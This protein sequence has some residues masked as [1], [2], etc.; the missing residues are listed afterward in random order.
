M[1]Q[2]SPQVGIHRRMKVKVVDGGIYIFDYEL[3]KN[4]YLCRYIEVRQVLTDIITNNVIV[5]L[6]YIHN[7]KYRTAVFNRDI[8]VKQKLL[9]ELP[10]KGLDVSDRNVL[11]VLDYLLYSEQKAPDINVHNRLGWAY[12]NDERVFLHDGVIGG[13]ITSTYAGDLNIAPKGSYAEWRDIVKKQVIGNPALELALVLGLSSPVASIFRKLI[14]LDVLFFHIYGSSTTG[15]TTALTLATS[16]FGYPSKSSNGLIKTWLATNNALLAYLNGIHGIP[17]AIDEA[18]VKVRADYTDAI[19]Q[20]T[21]G[22]EKARLN[23]NAQS[24]PR[25]EW[26]GTVL[27]TAENSLLANSNHNNGLRVRLLEL[28]HIQWTTSA[29]NAEAL[30]SVL[31][32]NYGHA[33]IEFVEYLRSYTDE[34][35]ISCFKEAKEAVMDNMKAK[36]S[37]TDRIADKIAVVLLT[38]MLAKEALELDLDEAKVLEIL[39]NADAAQAEDRN[40]TVKAYEYLKSEVTSNIN[41]FVYKDNIETYDPNRGTYKEKLLPN[42]EIIGR[43]E[44]IGKNVSEVMIKP[45]KLRKML[46]EGGFTDMDG[47]LSDWRNRGI[48]DADTGKYTRK[49]KVL[50][51]GVYER[52]I[53]IKLDN[54]FEG[55]QKKKNKRPAIG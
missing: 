39:I 1:G 20:I 4:V 2:G 29:E 10:A 35:L 12:I 38:T 19:Y 37:F 6:E 52:V 22:L 24:R 54:E 44:M 3:N 30:K 15:K 46:S 18:S 40:I 31:I 49:R 25:A 50:D 41:K 5:E 43:L 16:P 21:D 47:I 34:E 53:V 13:N 33:G 27:S 14:G 48:I 55:E 9:N 23:K 51:N 8:F 36:D 11:K 28:G 42:G 32:D 26:S 7:G 17:M 45:E